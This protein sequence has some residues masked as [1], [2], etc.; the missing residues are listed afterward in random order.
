[1]KLVKLT[2]IT[3][4]GNKSEIRFKICFPRNSNG[5]DLLLDFI[6]QKQEYFNGNPAFSVSSEN[7]KPFENQPEME[8][9]ILTMN[10]IRDIAQEFH[11]F[12]L[13]NII[14]IPEIIVNEPKQED[15]V[16]T[17]RNNMDTSRV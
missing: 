12:L 11:Y 3:Q 10:W 8:F 17:T 1:M 7:K 6:K 15:Y 9:T 5:S 14:I 16:H 2:Q 4:I 13:K